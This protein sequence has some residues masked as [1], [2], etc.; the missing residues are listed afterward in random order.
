ME[1]FWEGKKYNY[2]KDSI[3]TKVFNINFLDLFDLSIELLFT[4]QCPDQKA[5]KINQRT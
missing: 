2:S 3:S 5:R 1:R 4:P